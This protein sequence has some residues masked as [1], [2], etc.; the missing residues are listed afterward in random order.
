MFKKPS[1]KSVMNI[2]GESLDKAS[3][4]ISEK[5]A[6]IRQTE[7]STCSGGDITIKKG[8]VFID[9][10]E[11]KP[12]DGKSIIIIEKL[13]ING[14][15]NNVNAD[16]SDIEVNGNTGSVKTSQGDITVS[17]N[18]TGD[19]TSS[20]GDIEVGGKVGGSTKTSMGDIIIKNKETV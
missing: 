8:R 12:G 19:V 5:I 4:K 18:V 2:L 11:Y 13:V 20:Q 1:F 7:S 6:D 16:Q 14:N 3:E 10:K 17:G 15:A 9:G